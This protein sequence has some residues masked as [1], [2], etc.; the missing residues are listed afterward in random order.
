M[1]IKLVNPSTFNF[2]ETSFSNSIEY[3]SILLTEINKICEKGFRCN[4]IV[5][6][7]DFEQGY[8]LIFEK[9]PKRFKYII[10]DDQAIYDFF[11]HNRSTKVEYTPEQVVAKYSE[12][13]EIHCCVRLVPV[14]DMPFYLVAEEIKGKE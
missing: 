14:S 6:D 8:V 5:Y 7:Q 11:A 3:A 1:A 4:G 10:K 2:T 12:M 9:T 13:G